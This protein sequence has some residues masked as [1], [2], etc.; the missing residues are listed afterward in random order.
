[1][2]TIQ[3]RKYYP[4]AR[5]LKHLIKYFWVFDS[6]SHIRLNHTILPVNN[7]DILFNFLAPMTFEKQGMIHETP[8]NVF[9]SGLT[10]DP[11]IMK[12]KGIIQTIGVSFFPLGFYPFFKIPVSEF[13]DDTFGLD[14]LLNNMAVELEE[15]LRDAAGLM[16]KT[17]LLEDFFLRRL[18]QRA[19]LPDDI[20]RLLDGFYHAN[21]GV[22]EF[23][24][25][26]DVHP[27][28]LERIFNKFVGTTPKRFLRLSRFQSILR[29]LLKTNHVDLTTLAHEFAFFDQMHFIKDFKS[30]TGHSPSA[31]LKARQ[32]IMQIMEIV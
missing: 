30:F 13:K 17:R 23:C 11:V 31:F 26:N 25:Q 9:F 32:S 2:T 16:D 29:T 24:R 10:G 18:N 15:R 21:M 27:R 7:I 6:Y 8:G 5:P 28:K 14:A 20:C 3:I 1:M 22:R 19:L 4:E 12:Q